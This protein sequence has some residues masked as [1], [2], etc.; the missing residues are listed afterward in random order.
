[1]RQPVSSY[2]ELDLV[3]KGKKERVCVFVWAAP[4]PTGRG[5][6]GLASVAWDDQNFAPFAFAFAFSHSRRRC[7]LY[8]GRR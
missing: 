6:A 5:L 3:E 4:A 8:S 2:R 7:R 1:M